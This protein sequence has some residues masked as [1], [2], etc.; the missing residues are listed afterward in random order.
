MALIKTVTKVF[1]QDMGNGSYFVGIHLLLED[2]GTPVIDRDF[3]EQFAIGQ[4]V[5]TALKVRIGTAA[6]ETI[7]SYKTRKAMFDSSAYETARTQIDGG[8]VI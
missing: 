7:D 1:P 6:Q 3:G 5:D 2:D 4:E 8:L